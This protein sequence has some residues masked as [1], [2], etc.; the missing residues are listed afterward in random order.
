[1]TNIAMLP[2]VCATCGRTLSRRNNLRTHYRSQHPDLAHLPM[3]ELAADVAPGR[4]RHRAGRPPRGELVPVA[5][6]PPPPVLP[7]LG[8][9]DVV[10]AVVDQLAQPG[11]V[12][13]VR[14]L[15][16]VFAWREATAVFLR[17]VTD[18]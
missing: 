1:M 8:V 7:A 12:I 18:T 6:A 4:V 16:A 10:L 15:S 3:A 11:G 9:D 2:A 14:H 13:P 17:D 5:A